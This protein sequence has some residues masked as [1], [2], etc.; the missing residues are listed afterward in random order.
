MLSLRYE[1]W[2]LVPHQSVCQTNPVCPSCG[3]CHAAEIPMH[4]L[5]AGYTA[6][7]R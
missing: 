6:A 7:R 3:T 1:A 4:V 2:A 5:S